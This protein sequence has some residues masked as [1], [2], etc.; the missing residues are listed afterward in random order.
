MGH[1]NHTR[2]LVHFSDEILF[3]ILFCIS[4]KTTIA[5][6]ASSLNLFVMFT[7]EPNTVN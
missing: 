2:S 7:V 1:Y 5:F 4:S 6:L 3:I